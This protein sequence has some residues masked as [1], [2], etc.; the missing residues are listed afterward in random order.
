MCENMLGS[1]HRNAT[2]FP[3][4]TLAT[5]TFFLLPALVPLAKAYALVWWQVS[6]PSSEYP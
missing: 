3:L 1:Q 2:D 4:G 5:H 6:M